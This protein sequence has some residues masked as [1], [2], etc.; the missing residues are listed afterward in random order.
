MANIQQLTTIK[1]SAPGRLESVWDSVNIQL[2]HKLNPHTSDGEPYV[3]TYIDKSNKYPNTKLDSFI[4]PVGGS[5]LDVDR[6]AQFLTSGKGLI[7]LGKQFLMQT[8]NAFNETRLYSPTEVLVSAGRGA[9]LYIVPRVTRH[10]DLSG[11]LLGA[12]TSLIGIS[13][14]NVKPPNGTIADALPNINSTTDGHGLLR[15]QTANS[16]LNKLKSKWTNN[17]SN[18]PSFISALIANIKPASQKGISFNSSEGA[19]GM[20]IDDETYRLSYNDKN[21][22]K[23]DIQQQWVA[24]STIIRK[25]GEYPVDASR[26]FVTVDTNGNITNNIVLTST[27]VN[28]SISGVGKV[29]YNTNQSTNTLKSGYRYGDNVGSNIANSGPFTNS[30]IMYQFY[31]YADSSKNYPS[32]KTDSLSVSSYNTLMQSVLIDITNTGFVSN[33]GKSTYNTNPKQNSSILQNNNTTING[34][35]KLFNTKNKTDSNRGLTYQYGVLKEYRDSSTK[36]VSDDIAT[37]LENSLRLPSS[38]AFDAINTLT[39]L[40][41]NK[42]GTG[43]MVGWSNVTWKPYTHD[44]LAFYFYDIVN[45][46]YIPFRAT[47]KGLAANDSATYDEFSFIGRADKIFNYSGFSRDLSFNFKIIINS[48]VELAPTWQRI[49]YLTTAVKPSNYTS[50]GTQGVNNITNRYIIPP[51]YYITIGDMYKNQPCIIK[52]VNLTVPED[53]SWETT[54]QESGVSWSHLANYITSPSTTN[55]GQLPREVDIAVSMNLLEKEQPIAGGANFG[56]APRTN[57][58]TSN[59]WNT[60][61]P[62]GKSPTPMDQ[63]LVV[64]VSS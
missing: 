13:T 52:S 58:F 44:Q 38:L 60:A 27:L 42:K 61:I 35:N 39:V 59:A 49:N 17:S 5:L 40:D 50:G 33:S 51:M 4:F 3:Y 26:L 9:T 30:D 24:G 6:M 25:N 32:K 36:L 19:Y 2:Y 11:G 14:G 54:S 29:G 22:I 7:W 62:L 18:G 8:G 41:V 53:A 56:N 63:S 55:Y 47:I 46:K 21:G 43:P 20:M 23:Q 1:P 28:G 64:S 34:Y 57:V 37:Q 48:I 12:L 16:G 15:A 31:D 45:Q 10:L